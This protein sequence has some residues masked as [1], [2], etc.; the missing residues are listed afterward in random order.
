MGPG[1]L[2]AHWDGEWLAAGLWRGAG[3]LGM[4]VSV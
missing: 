2:I 1:L 3:R 4:G